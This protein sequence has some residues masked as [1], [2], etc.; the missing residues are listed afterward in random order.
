M[1]FKAALIL[2]T[3]LVAGAIANPIPADALTKR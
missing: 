1:Q 3:A 2:V